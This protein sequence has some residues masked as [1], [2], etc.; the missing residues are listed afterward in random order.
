[1]RGRKEEKMGILTVELRD[2]MTGGTAGVLCIPT[3]DKREASRIEEAL[4][5]HGNVYTA[6]AAPYP[7]P[8]LVRVRT[9]CRHFDNDPEGFV[10]GNTILY[11]SRPRSIMG[12]EDAGPLI[13]DQLAETEGIIREIRGVKDGLEKK[14]YSLLERLSMVSGE[15]QDLSDE[16][17]TVCD[18]GETELDVELERAEE[19][20]REKK[21]GFGKHT[22]DALIY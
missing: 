7:A 15:L 4:S 21:A 6:P 9:V 5:G 17:E 20:V 14:V 19:L 11:R 8:G 2:V 10:Y 18:E 12:M 16:L 3:E 13:L 1:M 22:D